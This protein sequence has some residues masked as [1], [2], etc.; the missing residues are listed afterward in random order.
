MLRRIHI[1]NV[2][3]LEDVELVF[4]EDPAKRWHVVLGDNG[5]GKTTFVR[6]VA[7]A[8]LLRDSMA[9]RQ[10]RFASWIGPKRGEC[11]A[12][13]DIGP[14]YFFRMS[15]LGQNPVLDF[16]PIPARE[17]FSASFGPSRRFQTSSR[18]M[19]ARVSRHIS[20]F[21][22]VGFGGALE[23]MQDLHVKALEGRRDRALL[24]QLVRFV[25]ASGL[26]H[27]MQLTR[28]L[29]DQVV[30]TDADG[31]E[32]D[33]D[34]LADGYRSVLLL[35]F[36]LIRQMAEHYGEDGLFEERD[37]RPVVAREGLVL[38]DEVDAHLHPSWQAKVG[39]WF[40][41][42][43]PHVEFLVTTHSPLVCRAAARG[44]LWRLRAPGADGPQI[45]QITGD[46]LDRVVYGSLHQAL[47]SE[48][49]LLPGIARSARAT[50]KLEVLAELTR[51][52]RRHGLSPSEE[53]ELVALQALFPEP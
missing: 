53:H 47:E 30:F 26:P 35:T 39:D 37:G 20:A 42:A 27:G 8:L 19:G 43:F 16:P 12:A 50:E 29:S 2:R 33:A 10:R 38:I 46:Q 14:N 40:L 13:V 36:E 49:F 52:S 51:K 18:E 22:D 45:V 9:L 5:A 48:A 25:N 1:Q 3:M 32:V 23:W 6:A 4:P 24:D 44:T 28:I 34:A 41:D 31:V 11:V 7:M 15:W 21:E 17:I